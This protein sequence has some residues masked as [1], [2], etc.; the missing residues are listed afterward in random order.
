VPEQHEFANKRS[1]SIDQLRHIELVVPPE[2][3]EL[4]STIFS[5]CQKF[6]FVP[7]I[8][9]EASGWELMT[10][11]VSLGLGA[12]VVNSCCR[13]KKGVVGIP[14]KEMQSTDYFLLHRKDQHLFDEL[15]LLK[16]EIIQEVPKE[17][18]F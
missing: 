6:D 2:P 11:F 18:I 8:S 16:H 10:H 14:I 7:K 13:L 5:L 12:A 17:E 3:S 15:K 4:R 9:V 1:A